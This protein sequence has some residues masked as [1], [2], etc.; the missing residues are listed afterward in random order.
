MAIIDSGIDYNHGDLDS[1][2]WNNSGE[3][4]GGKETDNTDNDGNGYVD[5]WR[6]WDFVN[7]DNSPM[8]DLY[9]DY[10]GTHVAGIAGAEGNNSTGV[11]GVCWNSKLMALK[12]FDSEGNATTANIVSAIDYAVD[13][14]ADVINCSFGSTAYSGSIYSAIADAQDAG[15]LVVCAAGNYNYNINTTP[16]YPASYDLDNIISVLATDDDDAKASY[17]DYGSYAVDLGSPG[18]EDG[19]HDIDDILS[20]TQGNAYYYLS[21]TSMA[22]PFVTGSVGLILG[23]RPTI[24]WWQAKTIILKSV[25]YKSG[26]AGKAR[27]SGRLNVH[28]AVHYS[29]PTL[30]AAPTDLA[31]SATD[32]GGFYDIELTWTDNSNNESGFKIYMLS[33]QGVYSE[34]ASTGSNVTSYVLEDVGSGT[35]YFYVRAYNA[36]G[37]SIKSNNVTVKTM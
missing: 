1:N 26:L 22:A 33:S 23:Q 27:T 30:P 24:D 19:D 28:T 29:T 12:A 10:H 7:S 35:Y 37:V 15:V 4:G 13:K 31:G 20:T 6:G 9:P 17:S 32:D 5:D 18:G 16:F 3:I 2:I 25:D 21:G 8:D 11:A 14:G 36:D 34:L